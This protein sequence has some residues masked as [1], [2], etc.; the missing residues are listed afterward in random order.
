MQRIFTVRLSYEVPRERPLPE[1]QE[2]FQSELAA[3]WRVAQITPIATS[4]LAPENA[5]IKGMW[6]GWFVVVLE[7]S[8]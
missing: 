6:I 8:N 7:N 5:P 1:V 4:V 2:H 3:G